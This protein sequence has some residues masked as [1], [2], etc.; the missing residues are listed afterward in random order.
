MQFQ[1][2]KLTVAYENFGGSSEAL[3]AVL[4]LIDNHGQD[5]DLKVLEFSARDFRLVPIEE[6]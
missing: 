5:Y 2:L 4:W 6:G 3:D 1:E